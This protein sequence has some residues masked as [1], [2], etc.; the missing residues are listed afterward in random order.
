[1]I[2][3][4]ADLA[5]QERYILMTQTVMPRPIAWV[6][7]G[8]EGGTYNLAPFSYFN[9]VC[10]DPPLVMIS[11]GLG[12]QGS[13]KDSRVNIERMGRF[14]VNIVDGKR[15]EAMNLS[16][17]SEP[18]GVSEVD[19]L[20]LGVEPFEG[21]DLPRLADSPVSFACSV[22]QS[23]TIGKSGQMIVFGEVRRIHLEDRVVLKDAKG[24]RKIDAAAVDPVG[25]LGAGEYVRFGELVQLKRP[26]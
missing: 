11:V 26:K 13:S 4:L 1:M 18:Y 3:D 25:R 17:A 8:N 7:S 21:F 6:L 9:A 23:M 5:P 15:L 14:V 20:G 12:P 10:S 2:I 19:K 16:S 22:Y 24:R